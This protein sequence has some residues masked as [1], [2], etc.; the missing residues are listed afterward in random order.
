MRVLLAVLL[1]QLL[2]FLIQNLLNLTQ[3]NLVLLLHG[4]L[5]NHIA[6]AIILLLAWQHIQRACAPDVRQTLIV[7]I[8]VVLREQDDLG[9]EIVDLLGVV[10]DALLL[11]FDEF[12]VAIDEITLLLN[13]LIQLPNLL[14]LLLLA[15]LPRLYLLLE[16]A[17]PPQHLLVLLLQDCYLGVGFELLGVNPL[18]ITS[19]ELLTESTLAAVFSAALQ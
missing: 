5:H 17:H 3:Q 15:I 2:F 1:R 14:L 19:L 18:L 7:A 9:H 16:L 8:G 13:P 12:D 4:A 10:V 11:F 6:A